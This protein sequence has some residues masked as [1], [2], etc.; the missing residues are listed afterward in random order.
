MT[1][2]DSSWHDTMDTY[3]DI[4]HHGMVFYVI[5][6]MEDLAMLWNLVEYPLTWDKPFYSMIWHESIVLH[7][8]ILILKFAPDHDRMWFK[9]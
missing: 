7:S 9:Q 5:D 6:I 3:R 4:G 2:N 1:P 8:F